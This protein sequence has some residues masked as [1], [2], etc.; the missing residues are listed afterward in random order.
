MDRSIQRIYRED[1]VLALE[2]QCA[3]REENWEF[4]SQVLRESSPA[5][6]RCRL[7]QMYVW[8]EK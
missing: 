2:E 4:Y 5:M 3:H 1:E 8:R 6:V 7:D